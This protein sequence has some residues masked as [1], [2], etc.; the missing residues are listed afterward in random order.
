MRHAMLPWGARRGRAAR[1]G[2]LVL[3]ARLAPAPWNDLGLGAGGTRDT[4]R[5]LHAC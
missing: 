3:Q 5:W 1:L 2:P 4:Q